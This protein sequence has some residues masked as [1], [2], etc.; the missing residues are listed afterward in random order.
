MVGM[1]WVSGALL[2]QKTVR[3]KRHRF[4]RYT[5]SIIGHFT[6]AMAH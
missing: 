3:T 2:D 4:V 5:A 1:H 6:M